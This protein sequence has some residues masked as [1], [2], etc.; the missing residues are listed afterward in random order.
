MG[1]EEEVFLPEDLKA[2]LNSNKVISVHPGDHFH[3]IPLPPSAFQDLQQKGPH[4]S[5]SAFH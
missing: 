4:I 3:V 1:G 2:L 5:T